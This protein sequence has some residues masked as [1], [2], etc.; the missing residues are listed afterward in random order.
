METSELSLYINQLPHLIDD[1]KSI[2]DTLKAILQHNDIQLNANTITDLLTLLP[3]VI[4][5]HHKQA[6]E[7]QEA[8]KALIKSDNIY[9]EAAIIAHH[10]YGWVP[11]S[12][13]MGRWE[14]SHNFADISYFDQASGLKSRLYSRTLNGRKEFIYATAGT[15]TPKDWANNLTQLYGQSQQ[16]AKSIQNARELSARIADIGG[17]LIFAGHS[18]G[19]GEAICNALATNRPAIVFNPASISVETKT[20]NGISTSKSLSEQLVTNFIAENDPLTLTQDIASQSQLFQGIVTASEG[21]RHYV[22][23]NKKDIIP[24]SMTGILHTFLEFS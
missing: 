21:K 22:P 15:T 8:T 14:K 23:L 16:Y 18:L 10:V 6:R 17:S 11:D 2:I 20:A 3:T 1:G 9:L 19:G 24:H 7:Q 4:S 12:K 13:L 5:D